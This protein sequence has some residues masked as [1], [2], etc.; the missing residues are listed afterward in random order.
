ME[1]YTHSSLCLFT[2]LLFFEF[3]QPPF[4]FG[5]VGAQFK[6]LAVVGGCGFWHVLTLTF[7]AQY[8][9]FNGELF[10]ESALA[11]K[12]VAQAF[13]FAVKGIDDAEFAAD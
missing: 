11:V 8:D 9:V 5:N 13:V 1:R 7:L 6:C 2:F 4:C 10:Q 12:F 3:L